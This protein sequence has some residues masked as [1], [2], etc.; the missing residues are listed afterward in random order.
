MT[1]DGI[2]D[3]C[4]GSVDEDC[5]TPSIQ[6]EVGVVSANETW[7]TVNLSKSYASMVVLTTPVYDNTA[8]PQIVRVRN[9]SG[10][11]FEVQMAIVDG[12]AQTSATSDVHYLVVE[13]GVY[14]AGTYGVQLEAVKYLSTVTDENNSWVGEARSSSSWPGSRKV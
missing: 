7:T 12:G 13:E 10:S 8:P 2:D 9:A 5:P 14:D 11:S 1:C 3:D 4:D 6:A